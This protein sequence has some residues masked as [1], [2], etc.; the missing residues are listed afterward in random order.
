MTRTG[1]ANLVI[2]PMSAEDIGRVHDIEVAS[3]TVPWSETLF[4]A[5]VGNALSRPMVAHCG[6]TIAGYLCASL[7]IDEGHIL[8]LAVHPSFRG[9][10]IARRLMDETLEHLKRKGCRSVFLEVRASHEAVIRFYEK[11]GF[12]VLQRRMCYYVSPIDDAAIMVLR[13]ERDNTSKTGLAE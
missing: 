8:D 1:T 13:F 10:G 9:Q 11:C 6:D 3:F 5:E 12:S 2:S 4:L 7:V